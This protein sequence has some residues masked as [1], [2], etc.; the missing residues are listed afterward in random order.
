[1]SYF[2]LC[3]W[4]RT[5]WMH[6]SQEQEKSDH[7]ELLLQVCMDDPNMSAGKKTWVLWRINFSYFS[8][9]YNYSYSTL[10]SY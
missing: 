5:M 9:S 2:Y 10:L 8:Y 7:M 1:M 3:V 4:A 6:C